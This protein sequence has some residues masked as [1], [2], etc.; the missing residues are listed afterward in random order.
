M[1]YIVAMC[2]DVYCTIRLWEIHQALVLV[3]VSLVYTTKADL[4]SLCVATINFLT[5]IETF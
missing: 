2:H 5:N 1:Y 3:H 4:L